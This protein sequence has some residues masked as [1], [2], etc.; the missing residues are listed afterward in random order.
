MARRGLRK[1]KKIATPK[2]VGK[3]GNSKSPKKVSSQFHMEPLPATFTLISMFGLIVVGVFTFSQRI[4]LTWG[5][6]FGLIFALMFIASMISIT[7][8]FGDL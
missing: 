6:S 8:K 2:L 5:V 7:P 4:D 3:L 1:S